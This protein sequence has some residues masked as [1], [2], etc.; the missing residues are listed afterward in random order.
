MNEAL[1]KNAG[2]EAQVSAAKKKE[3]FTRNDEIDDIRAVLSTRNGRRFLW[4]VISHCG[5]FKSVWSNSAAIHYNSGKADVGNFLMAEISD[6]D[7]EAFFLMMK[8]NMNEGLK[9][10]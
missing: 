9:N 3:R 7:K 5:P 4:R 8:E 1:V 2:D 10:A 6:A